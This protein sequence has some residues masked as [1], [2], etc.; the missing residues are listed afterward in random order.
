MPLIELDISVLQC[1]FYT[2]WNFGWVTVW[3]KTWLNKAKCPKSFAVVCGA[4][5]NEHSNNKLS[6]DSASVDPM[7]SYT[8]DSIILA[9]LN[10]PGVTTYSLW[11]ANSVFTEQGQGCCTSS[12][13][14]DVLERYD[15]TWMDTRSPY[16]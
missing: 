15:V 14:E 9:F 16:M 7:R 10:V 8:A 1:R 12:A 5:L 13:S 3:A 11:Y 2:T 4:L 6:C